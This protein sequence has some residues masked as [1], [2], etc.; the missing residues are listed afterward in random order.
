MLAASCIRT[1]APGMKVKT[2]TD[3]A[4]TARRMVAELLLADQPDRAVAHDPQSHLWQVIDGQKLVKARFP[5]RPNPAAPDRSHTA[6]AVNLDACIQCNLCVRACREVQVNDVIGMAGRG[7]GEKIVFDF[8]DPMGASTCVACGECV[9]ACPTG[10]LMPATAAR[11]AQRPHRISRP[12][13]RFGMPLLRRRLPAHLPHQG[14]QAALRHRQGRPGEPPAPLRQGPLRL[15]LR[16]QS[17]APHPADDPQGR[18]AQARRR[19][20]RHAP[21]AGAISARPRWDEALDRAAAGL[22][23]IRDKQGGACAC[24]VRLGQGLERGGLSVPEAGA[25]RLR[26]QQCR[27]LHPA[28]PRLLG[29]G[30]VGRRRLRGGDGDLQRVQELR[31]HHRDRRQPDRKPSGRGDLLQAGG[32]ARR[33]AHRDGSAR[34]GAQAP[35]RPHAAV[36]QRHRRGDAQRHAQRD[37][38]REAVRPAIRPDLHRR[39]LAARRARQGVHAGADGADL[40]H[41]RR[42]AA[43]R[44]AHL[45]PRRVRDHLLG[46]GHFPAH[47]RHRQCA[48]PDRAVADLRPGR[49]AR[50]R[51]AS[52][53]RPEQRAGRVGRRADPDVLPGLRV[54]GDRPT[55][56]PGSRPPG[57]P[58]SIPRRD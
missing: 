12:R 2:Q 23:A 18:R 57:A 19:R 9:Q 4:A 16:P 55:F 50:H 7:H 32:Q 8:D 39:L 44:G 41:R 13:G 25:H 54:G 42:H 29:G 33:Q 46:H 27:S 24:R 31:R 14:R 34:P 17:A 35:R 45:C 38:H 1:P 56:A 10:A 48:L 30:A 26:L 47:P 22:K 6:M 20:A 3:R 49:P 52:A 37:R 36:R 40:R 11:R 21:C 43:H 51:A 53:A 58:R 5:A 28:V 15:R